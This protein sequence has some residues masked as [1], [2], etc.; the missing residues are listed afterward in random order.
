MNSGFVVEFIE[1]LLHSQLPVLD[2]FE[3]VAVTQVLVRPEVLQWVLDVALF[4]ES[5]LDVTHVQ[6]LRRQFVLYYVFALQY[7]VQVLEW[8]HVRVLK[9]FCVQFLGHRLL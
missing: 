6:T 8:Q 4:D 3:V 9:Q 7:V 1:L 5:V 2:A